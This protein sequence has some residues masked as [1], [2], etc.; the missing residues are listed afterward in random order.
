[1]QDNLD[2]IATGTEAPNQTEDS[3]CCGTGP[4]SAFFPIVMQIECIL[5]L[6]IETQR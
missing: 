1:M 4:V 6:C 2:V 3:H 5:V